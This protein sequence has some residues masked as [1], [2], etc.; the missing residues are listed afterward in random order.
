MSSMPRLSALYATSFRLEVSIGLAEPYIL[1]VIPARGGS[2]G[3]PRKN[4]RLLGGKPLIAYVIEAS[5]ASTRL[6]RS[7]VS[8]EDD[9]IARVARSLGGDVP[10][11]RPQ[12]L[13]LDETPIFPVLKHATEQVELEEGRRVDV[14]LLLQPTTP[15][16]EPAD[17]DTCIDRFFDLQADVIMTAKQS[18][19]S[20]YYNL[21]EQDGDSPWIRLCDPPERVLHRRQ[22]APN[23][24]TVHSGAYVYSREALYGYDHHLRM[25]RAGIVE[26]P[27]ERILD[28]DTEMDLQFAEF[29][30]QR[31]N[32]N[33]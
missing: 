8:T 2:K 24:W 10:F 12:V 7:V 6:T 3:L 18:E 30:M 9:E 11:K 23:S 5:R 29:L 13:A 19:A 22:E 16:C 4:I 17:I 20:P 27:D 32:C 28:I 1:G 15:F 14:I 31:R 25:P 26:L 21:I 33:E